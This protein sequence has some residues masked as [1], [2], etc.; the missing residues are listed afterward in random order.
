MQKKEKQKKGETLL[1]L[2]ILA[3]LAVVAAGIFL[4]Q[5]RYNPAVLVPSAFH[6]ENSSGG[7]APP[8][9]P[10]ELMVSLPENWVSMTPPEA[11]GP[12]D[13]SEKIDGKAELYLSSGFLGLQCQ[14]FKEAGSSDLWTEVF[15]Y[16]MGNASNAFSVFSSQRRDDAEPLELSQFSYRTENAL[17]LAYGSYYL[18]MIASAASERISEAMQSM[19]GNF[20]RDNRPEGTDK[21]ISVSEQMLFPKSGLEENS[22]SLLSAN[23]FGYGA[24]DQVFTATYQLE[25]KQATAFFSRRK[26]PSEAEEL[27]LGYHKFLTDFGGTDV[28]TEARIRNAEMVSIMDAYDLIFTCG[29]FFAGVHEAESAETAE[30]LA[31]MLYKRLAESN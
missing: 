12:D 29:S 21:E 25:N 24:L 8:S 20:I 18:E 17:F 14:R 13:L 7:I 4:A 22:I 11:F 15:I 27:A 31:D 26:T 28:E 9:Q 5:F 30:K 3:L 16:D 1:S 6:T 2:A 19:A 23:V 10:A